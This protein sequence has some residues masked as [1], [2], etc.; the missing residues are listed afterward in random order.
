MLIHTDHD[1]R[2]ITFDHFVPTD[3][4][5]VVTAAR[6]PERVVC[7]I[8]GVSAAQEYARIIGHERESLGPFLFASYPTLVRAGGAITCAR[9]NRSRGMTA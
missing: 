8:N 5:M 1:F 7:E 9:F 6:P 2:E 4:K 3:K